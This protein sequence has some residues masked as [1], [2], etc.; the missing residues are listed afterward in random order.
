[1]RIRSYTRNCILLVF[2]NN[3][4]EYEI[5]PGLEALR[6]VA[7]HDYFTQLLYKR[8]GFFI[9][10]MMTKLILIRHGQTDFNIQKRY[11]GYSNPS[12]NEEGRRQVN[13]LK[14]TL[15][16]MK[17]DIL[18]SSD[19]LRAMETAQILL[20][21]MSIQKNEKL[22]EYNFGV[23]EGLTYDE[24]MKTHAGIFSEWIDDPSKRALPEGDSFISFSKRINDGLDSILL[25]NKQKI[26]V[27]VTH[28]GPI[29]LILSN[30]LKYDADKFW[31]IKQ[32]NA[33]LNI[34]NYN[35][36]TVEVEMINN[37]LFETYSEAV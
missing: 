23:F 25:M 30:I 10:L 3:K 16:E 13:L 24:I 4:P 14:N 12:L 22:R 29:R 20:P 15:C 11:C 8:L 7:L 34:I 17:A 18:Y 31:K 19:L 35:G 1:M 28:S 36:L 9:G 37:Q 21:D 27:L 5:P 32:D 33:A 26:I 6:I 2:T